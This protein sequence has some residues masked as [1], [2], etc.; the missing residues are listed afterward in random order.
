MFQVGSR[1]LCNKVQE[2]IDEKI[3]E[4]NIKESRC[5]EHSLLM[6]VLRIRMGKQSNLN[7]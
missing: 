6:F 7:E 2:C 3:K 5:G 1:W 4:T